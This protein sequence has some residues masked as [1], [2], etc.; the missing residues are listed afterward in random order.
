LVPSTCLTF[1]SQR[2]LTAG[3]KETY[4]LRKRV[5][6]VRNCRTVSKKDM[7]LNDATPKM[8]VDPERYAVR[9][10]GV[11]CSAEPADDV[12]LGQGGFLY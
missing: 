2:S 7:A 9:A 10:D 6:A 12:P 8:H 3:I 5:E 1:V 11:L 4:G